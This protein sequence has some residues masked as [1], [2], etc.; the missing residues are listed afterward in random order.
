MVLS[1]H[2]ETKFMMILHCKELGYTRMSVAVCHSQAG[3]YARS[4]IMLGRK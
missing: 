4:Q 1:L 2:P 3:W